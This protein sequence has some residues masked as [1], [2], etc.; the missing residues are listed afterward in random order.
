M[1]NVGDN[2]DGDCWNINR[3]EPQTIEFWQGQS[4]RIHDR[5]RFRKAGDNEE[6]KEGS[7][8]G[9]EGWLIERLAP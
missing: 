1:K 8:Q 7:V 3:V 4:N 5:L 9:E 6:L 2:Q